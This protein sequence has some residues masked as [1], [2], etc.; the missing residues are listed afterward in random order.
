MFL[1]GT[2]HQIPII[3]DRQFWLCIQISCVSQYQCHQYRCW[4]AGSQVN[5]ISDVPHLLSMMNIH[6][7]KLLNS[8]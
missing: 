7:S 1:S 2:D 5:S 6:L 8:K 3:Y 4:E